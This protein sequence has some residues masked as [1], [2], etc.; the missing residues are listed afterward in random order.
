MLALVGAGADIINAHVFLMAAGVFAGAMLF[1]TGA[2]PA[3]DWTRPFLLGLGH[4]LLHVSLAVLGA[5]LW[6]ASAFADLPRPLPVL[7]ALV[8]YLPV[9]AV[10]ASQLVAGYLLV[11]N[12]F[13]VNHDVLFVAQ[14]IEDGKAFL[15]LHVAV[16]GTL[17]V[18]PVAVD[19]VCRRWQANPA[20]PPDSS[21]FAPAEPLPVRLVEDPIVLRN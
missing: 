14:G 21:W 7:L 18:Y 15:R 20:G 4:G 3:Y 1:A 16:D 10:V 11:A 8:V 9:A 17:T 19:R 5:Y 13:G 12:R 2:A 6:R